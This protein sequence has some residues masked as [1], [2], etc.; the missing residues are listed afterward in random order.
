MN[1]NSIVFSSTH[2]STASTNRWAIILAGGDETRLSSV[3]RT[4]AEDE[5]PKQFCSILGDE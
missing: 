4:I 5:R 1:H 3:T 2:D